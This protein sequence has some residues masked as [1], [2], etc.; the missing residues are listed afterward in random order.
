MIALLIAIPLAF[1]FATI[2][3]KKLARYIL[4]LVVL[5][6][7]AILFALKPHVGKIIELGNWP[8]VYGITLVFDEI[9]FYFLAFVNAIFLVISLATWDDRF[10]IP[11]LVL[12]AAVNGLILTG[13]FFNSFVFLEIIAITSYIISTDKENALGSFKYLIFGGVASIFYLIGAV[14]MYIQGGTLNMGYSSYIVGMSRPDLMKTALILFAITLLVEL[15]VLPFGLWAPDVYGNGSPLTPVVLGNVVSVAMVYLFSRLSLTFVDEP[16]PMVFYYVALASIL[17]SQLGALYQKNLG[18]TLAFASMA[19]TSTVVAALLT[20]QE[21]VVSAAL[22]YLFTDVIAKFVLFTTY[23]NVGIINF[24]NAKTTGIAFT[25]SSLSLIGVPILAGFWGKYYLLKALFEQENY[26]LP[27]VVL[28]STLIE[29]A[30]II[31]W[32][33]EQW[34]TKKETSEGEIE[35]TDLPFAPKLFVLLFALILLVIGLFPQLILEKTNLLA[36]KLFDFQSYMD[37]FFGKGGM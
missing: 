35:N 37:L 25:L 22:F 5:A 16:L 34:F 12:N 7:L 11:L 31:K 29:L 23:G 13:D 1:A 17:L 21:S 36:E 20:R 27:I 19:G 32:N 9:A 18:R 8:A 24:K 30:Y 28:V 33:L 3:L 26:V 10:S 15:K 2:P 14:F 4:P 6:N